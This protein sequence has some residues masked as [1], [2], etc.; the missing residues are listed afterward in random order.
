[1]VAQHLFNPDNGQVYT[2]I[3]RTNYV[4][5]GSTVYN[6]GSFVDFANMLYQI[7]G[8]VA[9]FN[10]AKKAVDYVRN[11]MTTGG[12]ISNSAG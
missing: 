4:D 10:D 3:D 11:S 1:M 6:Q 2:S 9:Y 12:I 8:D 5:K 7:T